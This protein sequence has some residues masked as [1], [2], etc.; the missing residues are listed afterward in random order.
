[1]LNALSKWY[2][3]NDAFFDFAGERATSMIGTF[4]SQGLANTVNA[5]AKMTHKSPAL[6][7]AVAHKAI[8]LLPNFNS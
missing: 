5:Y 7:E 8:P 4:N 3:K 1:M 2:V 6:F